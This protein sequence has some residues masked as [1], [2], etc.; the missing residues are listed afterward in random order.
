MCEI[1][2]KRPRFLTISCYPF[3]IS[4]IRDFR[5]GVIENKT[6]TRFSAPGRFL[7]IKR[8]GIG[9]QRINFYPIFSPPFPIYPPCLSF[10][11]LFLFFPSHC[12]L[13]KS[14]WLDGNRYERTKKLFTIRDGLTAI[15]QQ[16]IHGFLNSSSDNWTECRRR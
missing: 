16:G 11:F 9:R 14:S 8:S 3:V 12:S 7:E 1:R 2:G 10:P 5:G 13:G 6:S 15:C 4:S